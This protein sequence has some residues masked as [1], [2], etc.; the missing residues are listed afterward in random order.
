MGE[1]GDIV[2]TC[3]ESLRK[4]VY[5]PLNPAIKDWRHWQLGVSGQ[6]NAQEELPSRYLCEKKRPWFSIDLAQP[7]RTRNSLGL[8][9]KIGFELG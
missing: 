2:T 6:C 7:Q 8:G 3:R 4:H 1:E 9:Q 5:D